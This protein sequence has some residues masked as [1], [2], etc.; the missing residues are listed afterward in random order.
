MKSYHLNKFSTSN[1]QP[2]CLHTTRSNISLP[3]MF[4]FCYRHKPIITH[5]NPWS[6]VFIGSMLPDWSEVETG[7]DLSIWSY[8]PWVGVRN[9]GSTVWVSMGTNVDFGVLA[10]RHTFF[11]INWDTGHSTLYEEGKLQFENTF[12]EYLEFK[13][14]MTFSPKIISIGCLYGDHIYRNNRAQIV[15]DFQL[16]GRILS[17]SEMEEWTSC[18]NGMPGDIVNWKTENWVFNKS[19]TVNVSETEELDF[20]KDI[21]DRSGKSNHIFPIKTS[22]QKAFNLCEK[23]SGQ[24]FM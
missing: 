9:N 4:T 14:K 23:V 13:D 17:N 3:T 5:S 7:F 18:R 20:E 16:F 11:T 22:V 2:D 12:T 24:L 10:W 15:T 19:E 21:C 8:G 1:F 6:N